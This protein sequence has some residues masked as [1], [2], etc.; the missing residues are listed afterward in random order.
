MSSKEPQEIETCTQSHVVQYPEHAFSD[1][2][3][4]LVFIEME[5]F[6][7]DWKSLGLDDENDLSAL[8]I[9]IMLD[10]KGSPII[11]GTGGLRKMRF[12]P[13]EFNAGK[14]SS[15]RVCYSY[16]QELGIVLF[17]TAYKKG[18]MDNISAAFKKKIKQELRYQKELLSSGFYK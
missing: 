8:Q 11:Q 4:I 2:K 17:V 1:P 9:S 13:P 18:D 7:D 12:S 10:P 3:D 15:F 5:G 6:T 16:F 14:S